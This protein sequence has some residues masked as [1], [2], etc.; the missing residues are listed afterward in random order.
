MINFDD[1]TIAFASKTNTDLLRAYWL[2]RVINNNTLTRLAP[3]LTNIG[4]KLYLP[5]ISIVKATIYK[6]FCGGETIEECTQTSQK[7]A[8][9]KVGTILDYSVEGEESEENFEATAAE[10]CRTITKAKGNANIPFCV[11]K[12]TG[13]AEFGLLEKIQTNASLSEEEINAKENALKRVDAICKLAHD[14]DVR[15]MIDA[16]E[17]WIQTTIDN[18]AM[19][20]MQKYNADKAI[21]F[22]TIQLYRHDRL[23]FLKHSHAEA[24]AQNFHLGVKLVRGAYME[25]ER[26]RA[27]EQNYTDPIQLNKIATDADYDA[28]LAFCVANKNTIATCAGTHNEASTQ[29]LAKVLKDNN[30][31]ANDGQFYFS[32]LL[33]MSDNL[34][35]NL[36]NA[37]YN[38]AKYVP[39][40][41]VKSVLPY[42]F[43]RAQENTSI[44]GQMGRELGLIV[45]ERQR[46]SKLAI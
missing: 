13:V 28:A 19:L 12:I 24:T 6:H 11:F 20:M 35:F 41:P 10:I 36:A 34:T 1:T 26:R 29:L 46:R 39:Y 15:L 31:S 37:G 17:T 45:K 14:N 33:G 44:A 25:K 42:L 9:Y 4:I 27:A 22:N 38:V 32:Q 8:E 40:G 3:T 18:W 7:L 23:A 2:F 43:R 5:V 21:V 30:I 16:E